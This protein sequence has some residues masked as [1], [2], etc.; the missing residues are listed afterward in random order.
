MFREIVSAQRQQ[1]IIRR[2]IADSLVLA[3][4]ASGFIVTATV[5]NSGLVTSVPNWASYAGGAIEYRVMGIEAQF[6]PIVNAQGNLTTPAPAFLAVCGFS[7]GLVPS[8]FSQMVEGP[9]GR[10]LDG[11][12]PGKFVV[13]GKGYT[14]STLWTPTTAAIVGTEQFGIVA[15]GPNST[16]AAVVSSSYFRCILKFLVDF[17]SL[18]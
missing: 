8:T 17:R 11:F 7:S 14:D 4:N 13:S 18:D 15:V 10:V 6:F 16:P 1:R 3:T 12:R 9:G 5:A 2:V